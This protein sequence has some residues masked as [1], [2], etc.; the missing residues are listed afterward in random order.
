MTADEALGVAYREHF[1]KKAK[2]ALAKKD[3]DAAVALDETYRDR[4]AAILLMKAELKDLAA[5]ML[6]LLLLPGDGPA[7]E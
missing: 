1:V 2:L 6:Q 4:V 5:P 3:L 7:P